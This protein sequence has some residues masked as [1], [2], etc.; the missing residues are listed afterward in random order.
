M[1]TRTASGPFT[2]SQISIS[3]DANDNSAAADGSH[4]TPAAV[5]FGWSTSNTVAP[6]TGLAAM[7][8]TLG[9]TLFTIDGHN[10]WWVYSTAPASAGVYY[11]W[12]IATNSAGINV[13]AYVSPTT[14]TVT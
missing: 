10:Q 1:G 6:T 8:N 14:Y 11:M 4:T 5:S 13:A 3:V 9:G 7:A 2:P 12:F